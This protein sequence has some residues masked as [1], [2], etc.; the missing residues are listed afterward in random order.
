MQKR[1][2][3]NYVDCRPHN[4]RKSTIVVSFS[5]RI[6]EEKIKDLTLTKSMVECKHSKKGESNDR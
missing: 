3:I 5:T 1:I 6:D 4:K 2:S